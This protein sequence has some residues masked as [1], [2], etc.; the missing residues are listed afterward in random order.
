VNFGNISTFNELRKHHLDF[1]TLKD[2]RLWSLLH[3]AVN[4]KRVEMIRLL[5]HLGANPH[6]Q[7]LPGQFLV[8]EELKGLAV[9]P[10]DVAQLRGPEVFLAY[11]EALRAAGP[12][13][14][15]QEVA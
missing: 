5:I 8:P 1:L 12:A 9:T 7:S 13:L 3:V 4:A 2:V 6:A 15:A 11:T 14:E 10:G